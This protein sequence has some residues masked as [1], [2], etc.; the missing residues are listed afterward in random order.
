MSVILLSIIPMIW[1]GMYDY[2]IS[3]PSRV[4]SSTL[5]MF[6]IIV[7]NLVV[8]ST[9]FLFSWLDF[10]F[11]IEVLYMLFAA[12]TW[13]VGLTLY[14]RSLKSWSPWIN[15][16]I[17]NAYPAI[18]VCIGY[19]FLKEYLSFSQLIFLLFIL[20]WIIFSSFHI[21]EIRSFSFKKSKSSFLF[22]IGAT[23][24]WALYVML[25]DIAV[26]HFH[27]IIMAWYVDIFWLLLITPFVF[28]KRNKVFSEMKTLSR[29][30]SMYIVLL[31][32]IGSASSLWFWYA[33]S[34]WS[35]AI[36]SAIAACSPA[37][38]T[39]LARIFD[40]EKLEIIQYIAIW[41]LVFWIAGL[42]YVSV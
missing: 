42:S 34:L 37:A 28:L 13:Y 18:T 5:L 22:A 21:S 33:F 35:L 11:Q 9:I 2:I 31:A 38:T 27:P 17:A 39:F 20:I 15:S 16:S 10:V 7:S 14:S 8:F 40:K 1:Y 29:K 25:L 19:F 32:L 24:M 36:V 12:I 41:A 3:K 30:N 23:F 4:L 26:R 6:L